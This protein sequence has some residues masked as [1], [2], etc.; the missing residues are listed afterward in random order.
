MSSHVYSTP[1]LSND[2][3]HDSFFEFTR[4]YTVNS[5]LWPSHGFWKLGRLSPALQVEWP[6]Q[7]CDTC[8]TACIYCKSSTPPDSVRVLIYSTAI[9]FNV[10]RRHSPIE[11]PSQGCSTGFT[12]CSYCRNSSSRATVRIRRPLLRFGQVPKRH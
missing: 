12:V 1:I 7:A 6:S 2:H 3:L 8:F 5:I 9:L 4:L 11:W 10:P